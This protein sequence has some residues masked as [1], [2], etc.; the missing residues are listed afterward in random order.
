MHQRKSPYSKLYKFQ[1]IDDHIS[2]L[3]PIV[4]DLSDDLLRSHYRKAMEDED[5]EYAQACHVEMMN[6]NISIKK[7]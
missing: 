5:Y 6:R 4:D 7:S 1:K 3:I 2:V